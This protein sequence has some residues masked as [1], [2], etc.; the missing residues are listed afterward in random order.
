L[1]AR[2]KEKGGRKGRREEGKER[3]R[4]K[5]CFG[6]Y[7]AVHSHPLLPPSLPP[8]PVEEALNTIEERVIVLTSAVAAASSSSSPS[9][10]PSN[11]STSFTSFSLSEGGWG[12]EDGGVVDLPPLLALPR[13]LQATHRL[14]SSLRALHAQEEGR[15]GGKE[16]EL[17]A[18]LDLREAFRERDQKTVLQVRRE[19]GRMGREE[20]E[21]AG[22]TQGR[23]KED[24]R[25]GERGGGREKVRGRTSKPIVSSFSSF[26]FSTVRNGRGGMER[27]PTPRQRSPFLPPFLLPSLLLLLLVLPAGDLTSGAARRCVLILLLLGMDLRPSPSHCCCC[28]CCGGGGGGGRR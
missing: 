24:G 1:D 25:E 21:V 27:N 10:P 9:S 17:P 15:E 7:P 22:Q 26:S 18:P 19:R 23:R 16:G 20:S 13:R 5:V 6:L 4:E 3:G 2:K 8:S 28:C 12:K 14:L 11:A